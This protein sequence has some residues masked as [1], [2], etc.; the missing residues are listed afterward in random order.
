KSKSFFDK[1]SKDIDH[2]FKEDETTISKEKIEKVILACNEKVGVEDFNLLKEKV[3]SYNSD[4]EF[5]LITIQSLSY[6]LFEFPK[7]TSEYLD[8]QS[9]ER[10]VGKECRSRDEQ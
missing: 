8:I 4:T 6:D 3:K 1:L 9:E 10:R 5:E 2:C 7:L